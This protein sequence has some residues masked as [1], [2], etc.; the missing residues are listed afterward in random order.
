MASGFP[1]LSGTG[2]GGGGG[3]LTSFTLCTYCTYVHILNK[4]YSL[5]SGPLQNQLLVRNFSFCTINNELLNV[6][7]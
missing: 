2:V 7:F 3:G 6:G 4:K 1:V 5:S